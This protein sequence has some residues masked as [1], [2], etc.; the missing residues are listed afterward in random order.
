[1]KRFEFY[2]LSKVVILAESRDQA[3][4]VYRLEPKGEEQLG[5]IVI[6]SDS[7][8]SLPGEQVARAEDYMAMLENNR[9]PPLIEEQIKASESEVD[10]L[11]ERLAAHMAKNNIKQPVMARALKVSSGTISGWLAKKWSP[12]PNMQERIKEFLK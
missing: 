5:S 9:R 2:T 11:I 7:A 8:W 1:M 3:E 4:D 6:E 12:G 10:K